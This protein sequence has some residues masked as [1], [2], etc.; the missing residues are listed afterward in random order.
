MV[1]GMMQLLRDL[2]QATAIGVFVG[3]RLTGF[4][5]IGFGLGTFFLRSWQEAMIETSAGFLLVLFS[6]SEL[7]HHIRLS[8]QSGLEK[9]R[10]LRW[11]HKRRKQIM[12]AFGD[13][14]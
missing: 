14:K 13:F 6:Y 11:Q 10:T 2:R 3:M 8:T 4:F 12:D 9:F 5:L 7:W 1:V